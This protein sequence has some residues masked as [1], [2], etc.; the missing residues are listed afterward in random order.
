MLYGGLAF[1]ASIALVVMFG[2]RLRGD[3]TG[4]LTGMAVVTVTWSAVAPVEFPL[5]DVLLGLA[6]LAAAPGLLSGKYRMRVP[7]PC[8]VAVV[9]VALMVLLNGLMQSSQVYAEGRY[10]TFGS[11]AYDASTRQFL[12]ALNG[13]KLIIALL[14]LPVLV[15]VVARDRGRLRELFDLWALSAGAAC[16]VALTDYLGLTQVAFGLGLPF[17]FPGARVSGLT[18]HPVHLSTVTVMAMPIVMSWLVQAGRRRWCGIALL[19]V[20]CAGIFVAGSRAGLAGGAIV[21]LA[22]AMAFKPVRRVVTAVVIPGGTALLG[23]VLFKIDLFLALLE[24]VRLLGGGGNGSDAAR[25]EVAQQALRDIAERPLLGIGFDVSGDGH[26]VYLQAIAAGGVL[27]LLAL[28]VYTVAVL[29]TARLRQHGTV[30]VLTV[31]CLVSTFAWLMLAVF[32]NALVER[33]MYLPLVF[34]LAIAKL[35]A[36]EAEATPRRWLRPGVPARTAPAEPERAGPTLVS[37]GR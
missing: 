28:I 1:V 6:L 25:L 14:V 21:L 13:L 32:E 24:K 18:N 9:V 17:G 34:L 2:K 29:R 11:Q 16:A 7:W 12:N 26:S 5:S 8:L 10:L 35:R 36:E 19:L 4:L 30:D 20:M 33:Y 31:A 23:L 22:G 15:G 37:A 27:T 3:L